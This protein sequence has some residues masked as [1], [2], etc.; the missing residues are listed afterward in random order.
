MYSYNSV[1]VVIGE[2]LNSVKSGYINF[3]VCPNIMQLVK[4]QKINI[5]F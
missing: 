3:V 4:E 2:N 1:I 5:A